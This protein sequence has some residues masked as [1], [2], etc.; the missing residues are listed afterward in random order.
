MLFRSR[1]MPLQWKNDD[2]IDDVT[3]YR[4]YVNS[5]PWVYNNYIRLPN[6]RPDWITQPA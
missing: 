4:L 2:T 5:K 6:R 3:A 1:A